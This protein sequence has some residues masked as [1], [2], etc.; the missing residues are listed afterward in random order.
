MVSAAA[1][2]GHTSVAPAATPLPHDLCT[3][4]RPSFSSFVA[5]LPRI[6]A[7]ARAGDPV[8]SLATA[9]L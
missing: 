7:A 8:R 9:I 2:Y 4:H 6:V 3:P 1:E 5:P